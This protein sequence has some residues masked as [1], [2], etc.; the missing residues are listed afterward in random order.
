MNI[1]KEIALLLM[2]WIKHPLAF[3]VFV[4]ISVKLLKEIHT[5]YL[6]E[7]ALERMIYK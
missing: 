3:V 1:I 2:D 5:E 4:W 6:K 7:T